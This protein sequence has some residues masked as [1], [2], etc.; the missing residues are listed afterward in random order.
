MDTEY[1]FNQ[2]QYIPIITDSLGIINYEDSGP[3]NKYLNYGDHR[4]FV[5]IELFKFG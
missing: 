4:Y 1:D 5:S 2:T 3:L